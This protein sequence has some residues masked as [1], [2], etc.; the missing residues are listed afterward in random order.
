[1]QEFRNS[2]M[3][4]SNKKKSEQQYITMCTHAEYIILHT[5]VIYILYRNI[6]K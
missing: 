6:D 1:M 5:Q 4:L 2:S 3:L